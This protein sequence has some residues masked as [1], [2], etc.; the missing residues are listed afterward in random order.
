MVHIIFIKSK[1]NRSIVKSKFA[2]HPSFCPNLLSLFYSLPS[3]TLPPS[4]LSSLPPSSSSFLSSLLPSFLL[5]FLLTDELL[6]ARVHARFRS[7]HSGSWGYLCFLTTLPNNR[8]SQ[9]FP[10]SYPLVHSLFLTDTLCQLPAASRAP[11]PP[12]SV[13]SPSSLREFFT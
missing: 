9:N 11:R 12:C 4:I 8:F 6:Y 2:F 10:K 13:L 3:T 7:T 1:Q 5:F